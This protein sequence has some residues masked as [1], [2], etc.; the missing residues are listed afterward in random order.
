M[1]KFL[2]KGFGKMTIDT[3]SVKRYVGQYYPF[4]LFFVLM[5]LMH[6]VMGVNGDDIRYAKVLS[7]QTLVDYI[8]YRY[9]NWSS[10][11][12][13]ESI[14][15]V[16]VRQNMILW[17]IIDCVLY[18]V[19]VYYVIR[20][21]N[22]KNSTHIALLG[23]L[24][25]L[26]YPFHE[27]AT[28]GW[29]ATTLNYLWPFSFAM[30]SAIPLIN[31]SYGKKTSKL[32]YVISALALI[33]AVQQ[34]QCCALIFGLN[35]V[36]LVRC[37]LKKEELNRYNI[38]VILV[39]F[40][41][42]IFIFT[43]PGNSIRYAEE[44]SYWYPQYANYG[45]L[46]KIYLGFIPT[47]AL[48]LEEKII[49]PLFY[50]IL[51]VSALLK[52]ENKYWKR[53]LKL[54]IVFILFLVVFKTCLD[55][56]IL[57]SALDSATLSSLAAPFGAFVDLIWPLKEALLVMGYETVPEI[58][59]LTI[60]IALYLLVSSCW[61]LVKVFDGYDFLILFLAGFMSKFVTGFSPTVFASGPRTLVFFYF[62]LIGIILKLIVRLFDDG[63]INAKWDRL[64]T[65]SFIVLAVV[66]Y[67][68]VFG[69]VFVKYSLF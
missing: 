5:I 19:G 49:F 29:M 38:F 6:L 61:M 20:I 37:Y 68:L 3:S 2:F 62:I 48:L 55:V 44:L 8:S 42:L 28:A 54:N 51:T 1:I 40:A 27:M 18:T 7:N 15:I 35:L 33:Y 67:V 56:S 4:L 46:E 69:I 57:G 23:V 65:L 47:F 45:I 60:L 50:L 30:I 12:L 53:F 24:L 14:L 13:I 58:N 59:V 43:C 34:E 41:S 25:F 26:M 64:M 36:Y 52:V 9:Y 22:R 31:M 11:V 66:N 17:E 63:N 32:V 39:S 16:L 21:F 10:R